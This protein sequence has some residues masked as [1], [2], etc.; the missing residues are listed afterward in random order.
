MAVETGRQMTLNGQD[1]CVVL[2]IIGGFSCISPSRNIILP[3]VRAVQMI[4]REHSKSSHF[5]DF[6]FHIQGAVRTSESY[7]ISAPSVAFLR[8]IANFVCV[9]EVVF[10]SQLQTEES[11]RRVS[12]EEHTKAAVS[13]C[14]F[15]DSYVTAFN[16]TQGTGNFTRRKFP[17]AAYW[18]CVLQE[19]C[20][21]SVRHRSEI[22]WIVPAVAGEGQGNTASNCR[23]MIRW[24]FQKGLGREVQRQSK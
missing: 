12:D 9:R 13:C 11:L 22:S 1:I 15:Y 20:T 6:G 24:W 8:V 3:S 23:L 16:V 2:W 14:L 18:R 4:F 17:P 7:G 21:N 10:C 19:R 5:S